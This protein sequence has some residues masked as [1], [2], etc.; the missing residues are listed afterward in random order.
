M[1]KDSI[2]TRH[3]DVIVAPHITEKTTLLSENNAVV[4]KVAERGDQA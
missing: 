2:D 1:A 3:Y 4:F